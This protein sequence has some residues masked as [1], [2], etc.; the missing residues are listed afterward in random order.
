MKRMEIIWLMEREIEWHSSTSIYSSGS[1]FGTLLSSVIFI[2]PNCSIIAASCN[3]SLVHKAEPRKLTFQQTFIFSS[4]VHSYSTHP[5]HKPLFDTSRNEG[6]HTISMMLCI[7]D[8]VYGSCREGET[9]A[10]RGTQQ[11]HYQ[12]SYHA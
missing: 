10:E 4:G 2:R 1:W 9:E 7:K 3:C 12:G 11:N 6:E 8:L 5:F